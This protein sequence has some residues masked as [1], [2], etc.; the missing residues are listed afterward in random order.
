MKIKIIAETK[1]ANSNQLKLLIEVISNLSFFMKSSPNFVF[2][3]QILYISLKISFPCFLSLKNSQITKMT[4]NNSGKKIYRIISFVQEM[5]IKSLNIQAN[6]KPAKLRKKGTYPN[7]L[8]IYLFN[9]FDTLEKN[10][11]SSS[12][13][14]LKLRIP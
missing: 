9:L 5:L 13:E 12:F 1:S 7:I 2:S 6:S 11:L 10:S 4:R 14:L 8:K 3:S